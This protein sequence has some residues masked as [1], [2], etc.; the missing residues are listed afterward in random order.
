MSRLQPTTLCSA[1]DPPMTII[2]CFPGAVAV[3]VHLKLVVG[4]VEGVLYTQIVVCE[5]RMRLTGTCGF[6][7]QRN[8]HLRASV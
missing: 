8:Q 7:R 2:I 3:V 4:Y 6:P 5:I 1:S